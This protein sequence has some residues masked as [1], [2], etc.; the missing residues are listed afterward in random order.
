MS[1]FKWADDGF[2]QC[3]ESALQNGDKYK[4]IHDSGAIVI[5]YYH[6]H[7]E[8]IPTIIT[9][10]KEWVNSELSRTDEL[11]KL[12]DY[13]HKDDLYAYRQELRDYIFDGNRPEP[14]LTQNGALI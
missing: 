13:P 6:E 5:S 12:L 3:D 2:I 11:A 1:Y 8:Q 9:I 7:S 14:R 10:E 4:L